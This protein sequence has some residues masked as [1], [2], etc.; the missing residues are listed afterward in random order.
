MSKRLS[1]S[2][3]L[4]AYTCRSPDS[5]SALGIKKAIALVSGDVLNTAFQQAVATRIP[6]GNQARVSGEGPVVT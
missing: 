1:S 6:S 3:T 5:F 2:S 4:I